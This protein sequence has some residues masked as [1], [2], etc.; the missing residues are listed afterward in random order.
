[1]IAGNEQHDTKESFYHLEIC[2]RYV[3]E[4]FGK[5][6]ISEW[7]NRDYITLS[8]IVSRHT[9][10][11]ISASTLKRIFGKLKT[12]DRYY[13][14][15]ATR[16]ALANYVAYSD[17]ASFVEKHPRPAK[18]EIKE[19]PENYQHLDQNY[20]FDR[21]S[22]LIKK[23]KKRGLWLLLLTMIVTTGIIIWLWQKNNQPAALPKGVA[24]LICNN[25]TGESPHSAVFS[26]QLPPS[27]SVDKSKFTI[28]FGD[29]RTEG[30]IVS[31]ILL[32]HFYESPGRYYA[33]LKYDGM[34][35]DTIPVYLTTHEWTATAKMQQDTTRVYPVNAN[36]FKSGNMAVTANEIFNAG[37][38][39]NHTFFVHFANTRPLDIDGDNF[40]MVANVTTSLLRPG[41]RCSQ[42]HFVLYGERSQ[43]SLT[44]IKP[45]CVSWANV[46]FSENYKDGLSTDLSFLGTDLSGGG[47]VRLK[48]DKKK[49]QLWVNDKMVHQDSYSKGLGNL[50]GA[51]IGFAG[52]G[53]VNQFMLKDQRTGK[54]F[55]DGFTIAK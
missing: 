24:K 6:S 18:E 14:Q 28:D 52:I 17:W 9:D 22:V 4:K 50:Y 34:H 19:T 33:I 30:K 16:D 1:M 46:K 32:T 43:H 12:S 23:N 48:V 55:S 11:L 13:P 37:V 51:K 29:G 10:I 3:A 44:F 36:L 42:V 5:P 38:D 45:G 25:A 21:T 35:I 8:G 2:L 27:F 7:T 26:L 54:V 47:W 20:A 15:K 39:T 53:K 40:E 41:I 49:V 31:G